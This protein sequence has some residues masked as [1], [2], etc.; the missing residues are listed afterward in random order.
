MA[1]RNQRKGF[2]RWFLLGTLGLVVLNSGISVF[3]DAV[4]RKAVQDSI[5]TM[6][7]PAT[8]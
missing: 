4:K 2:W 6:Q 1:L 3:G 8:V 7:Q 5:A